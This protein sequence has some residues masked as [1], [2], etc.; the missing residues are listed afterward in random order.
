[1]C[2]Y[3]NSYKC[4]YIVV[5]SIENFYEPVTLGLLTLTTISFIDGFVDLDNII[6]VVL[7]VLDCCG[8]GGCN[9]ISM[10]VEMFYLVLL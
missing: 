5:T 8:C 4:K 1:M 2:G 10:H 7:F 3:P 9:I 6:F